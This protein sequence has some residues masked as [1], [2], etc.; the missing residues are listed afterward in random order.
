MTQETRLCSY[1]P[2]SNISHTLDRLSSLHPLDPWLCRQVLQG[3]D[4]FIITV[5]RMAL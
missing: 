2:K 5:L 3:S 4:T 1:Q